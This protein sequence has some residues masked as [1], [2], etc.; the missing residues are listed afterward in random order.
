MNLYNDDT[1][2]HLID[3]S[4]ELFEAMA[5]VKPLA[6]RAGAFRYNASVLRALAA[7]GI[8]LSFQYHPGTAHKNAYPHGFDAGVL[9]LFR[10]SNGLL[11]VPVGVHENRPPRGTLPRYKTFELHELVGGIPQA[12]VMLHRHWSLGPGYEVF[13]VLLHSWSLLYRDDHGHYV[14]RDARRVDLF[15]ELLARL[16]A[17]G[18][19]ISTRDLLAELSHQRLVPAFEMPIQVAGTEAI[20]PTPLAE[21]RH[22]AAP[23]PHAVRDVPSPRPPAPSP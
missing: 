10:W 23:E 14:W 6:F 12:E 5:G 19:V 11:E 20:P 21:G 15:R 4:V 16:A 22:D 9:P 13:V 2:W 17:H 1:A 3:Y 18:R 7:R 8:P